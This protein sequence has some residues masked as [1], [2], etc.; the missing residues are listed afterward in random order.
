MTGKTSASGFTCISLLFVR[1]AIP[2]NL[3]R[4]IERRHSPPVHCPN[5][6]HMLVAMRPLQQLQQCR[7][8]TPY[9]L[10]A[11]QLTIISLF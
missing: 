8:I 2:F 11:H 7:L 10:K 3:P 6:D 9:Y 5:P 1:L 4:K